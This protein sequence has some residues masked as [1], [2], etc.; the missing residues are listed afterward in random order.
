M[1]FSLFLVEDAMQFNL[2]PETEHEKK[3][4]KM[5]SDYTGEKNVYE[6]ADINMCRGGYLRNFSHIRGPYDK[7]DWKT[8]AIT[9][10]KPEAKSEDDD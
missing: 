10:K 7:R 2:E 9:I 4:I 8:L 6:G 1:R 3:F 5:I